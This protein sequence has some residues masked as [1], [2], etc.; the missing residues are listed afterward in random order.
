MFVTGS[1]KAL[2]AQQL[3]P[4]PSLQAFIPGTGNLIEKAWLFL[5]EAI[6]M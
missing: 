3:L 5:F 6:L 2:S 4:M 1:A